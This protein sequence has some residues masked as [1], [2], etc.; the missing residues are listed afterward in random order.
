MLIH[1]FRVSQGQ[2]QMVQRS[3]GLG[4]CNPCGWRS[5]C[6]CPSSKYESEIIVAYPTKLA[7]H[8]VTI[9]EARISRRWK[10][11]GSGGTCHAFNCRKSNWRVVLGWVLENYWRPEQYVQCLRT[12]GNLHSCSFLTFLVGFH[13]PTFFFFILSYSQDLRN[14]HQH[15]KK[16]FVLKIVLTLTIRMN[17][18]SDFKQFF[19]P[20]LK[21]N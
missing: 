7:V 5:R 4:F 8:F 17:Y 10:C 11:S 19:S 9:C 14:L 12:I 6:V 20:L 2:M 21:V 15:V 16:H 1:F 13:I 18:C 3:E